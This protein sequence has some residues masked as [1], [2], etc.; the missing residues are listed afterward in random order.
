MFNIVQ[1][2]LF[3]LD[4]M[5]ASQTGFLLLSDDPHQV[6][7]MQILDIQTERGRFLSGGAAGGAASGSGRHDEPRLLKPNASF[8]VLGERW[9]TSGGRHVQHSS[10]SKTFH[11]SIGQAETFTALYSIAIS[12]AKGHP[13]HFQG[14]PQTNTGVYFH[15][16][17]DLQPHGF[18]GN[19]SSSRVFERPSPLLSCTVCLRP[20]CDVAARGFR[21]G[22]EKAR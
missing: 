2:F 22:Q 19:F 8:A 5:A 13:G 21:N 1:H 4:L 15:R 9:H 20:P 14:F 7:S 6:G 18:F 11:G 10:K 12:S 3:F 16:G 17:I